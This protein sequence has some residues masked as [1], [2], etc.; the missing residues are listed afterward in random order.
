M[1]VTIHLLRE[2]ASFHKHHSRTSDW[3]VETRETLAQRIQESLSNGILD[4]EL[5]PVGKLKVRQRNFGAISSAHLFGIDEFIIFAWYA[6]NREKYT[7]MLDL[8]GNI[9]V[10]SLVMSKLGFMVTAFEP[11]PIHIEYFEQTMRE[12]NCSDVELR[13]QAIGVSTQRSSFTRVLGNTTGSHISGAKQDP[14][15]DLEIFEVQVEAIQKVLQEDFDFI[16]MDV[17]GLEAVLIE[18]LVPENFQKLEIMLEVGTSNNALKIFNQLDRL[19]INAFAQKKAWSK[20]VSVEDLPTSHHE[21]SVL[22]TR[23]PQMNWFVK[24][25]L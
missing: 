16:K 8:G 14:Y 7:K 11:D 2:I 3:W 1:S 24:E 22:L 5:T 9:G 13:S 21:G 23:S 19:G 6:V 4:L 15:G 12:N 20:V 10:H 17:E 18:T 25:E